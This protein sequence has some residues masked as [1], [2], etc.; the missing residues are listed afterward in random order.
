MSFHN[1]SIKGFTLVELLISIVLGLLV[2]AAAIQVLYTSQVGVSTQQANSDIQTDAIFGLGEISKSVR[3][4]NYGARGNGTQSPYVMNDQTIQ[5]GIVLNSANNL[6]GM[7]VIDQDLL[8]SSAKMP[9]NLAGQK[10]DQLVVQHLVVEDTFNCEGEKVNAGDYVIERYFLRVDNLAQSGE[11]TALGL[12]CSAATYNISTGLYTPNAAIKGDGEII[13]TRVDHF[14]VLYGI[15]TNEN[16][17]VNPGLSRVRYVDAA[18]YNA[19]T[20][21]PKPRITTVKLAVLVRSTNTSSSALDNV[22]QKFDLLDQKG[23]AL[24]ADVQSAPRYQRQV[25][26][27]TI[28]IRN[29]RGS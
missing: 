21:D 28:A 15:D 14:R 2:T 11:P 7:P 22:E 13:M 4:A 5:G 23:L 25:F 16:P 8:T 19:L 24:K 12:A 29:A 6:N 26:S 20:D 9:S 10:S 17:G 27:N 18:E 3:M 1:N